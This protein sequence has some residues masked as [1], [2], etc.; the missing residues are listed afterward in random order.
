M[1][2]TPKSVANAKSMAAAAIP[3]R[4]EI[5]IF[6]LKRVLRTL[7]DD[8]K[9]GAKVERREPAFSTKGHLGKVAEWLSAESQ[10]RDEIYAADLTTDTRTL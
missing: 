10:R 6:S 5:S 7:L 4:M 1:Y 3:A 9:H 2:H 8:A